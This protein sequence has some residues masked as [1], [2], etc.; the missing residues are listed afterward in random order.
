MSTNLV[1]DITQNLNAN[2]VTRVASAFGVDSTQ[3]ESAMSGGIPALLATLT[4][5][6]STPKGAATLNAA[7]AQQQPGLLSSLT[8]MIGDAGQKGIVDAGRNTLTNLIGGSTLSAVAGAL[9]KYAGINEG[10]SKSIMGLL[11]PIVLGGLG[12]QQRASGL[13][14]SGLANLLTSQKDNIL[15]AIPP[16]LSRTLGDTGILDSL[17]GSSARVANASRD[18]VAPETASWAS[19]KSS[20]SRSGWLLPGA[21]RTTTLLAAK[22]LRLAT[23]LAA[24]QSTRGL[25]HL[26]A[27][28]R[29]ARLTDAARTRRLQIASAAGALLLSR[30]AST[31]GAKMIETPSLMPRLQCAFGDSSSRLCWHLV[32]LDSSPGNGR[33]QR[34]RCAGEVVVCWRHRRLGCRHRWRWRSGSRSELRFVGMEHSVVPRAKPPIRTELRAQPSQ[35][36][37]YYGRNHAGANACPPGV[38]VCKLRVVRPSGV[39]RHRR[40]RGCLQVAKWCCRLGTS[41]HPAAAGSA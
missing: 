4:S 26:V 28:A 9:G 11:A 14:A 6:A 13:D 15:R 27:R 5:L 21:K 40:L 2:L 31:I 32:Q 10:V 29:I 18:Y 36:C 37:W 17:A 38:V 1:S 41:P 12:Q 24:I 22:G 34:G 35:S 30:S 7:V 33:V 20:S 3:V 8:S 19:S 23:R 25:R 39:R 16:G